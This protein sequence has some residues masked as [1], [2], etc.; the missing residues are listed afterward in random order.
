PPP[1]ATHTLSLHDALPICHCGEDG[2]PPDRRHG[3][4]EFRKPFLPREDSRS[5]IA[6]GPAGCGTRA[7]RP[8]PACAPRARGCGGSPPRSVSPRGRRAWHPPAHIAL[9]LCASRGSESTRCSVRVQYRDAAERL[10][11]HRGGDELARPR[12]ILAGGHLGARHL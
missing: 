7:F 11:A 10:V 9:S 5:A 12:P 4:A 6:H 8:A 1:P 3:I 2:A